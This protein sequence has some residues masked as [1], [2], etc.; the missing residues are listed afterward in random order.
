KTGGWKLSGVLTPP[1]S[2]AEAG[3]WR[4]G[5]RLASEADGTAFYSETGNGPGGHG[6]PVLDANGF[7]TDGSYYE[8]LIKA[9]ADPAS[10]PTNQNKNGWGLKV[11]D[12]FIPFNQV[13]LDNADQDFG[14]GAPTLLPD[15]AGLAGVPHLMVATGKQGK[16]YLVN[17]DNLG[18]FDPNND[19]VLNAVP[20]GSGHNTPPVQ[21]GGGL[22]TAAF[23]N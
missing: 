22:S 20:D 6:N 7:P 13:A 12:Y 15:S 3:I 18:K 11:A 9:V 1:P 4:A 14:S 8:A 16:I 10:T 23:F 17:R 5:G 2:G 21:L 19:H